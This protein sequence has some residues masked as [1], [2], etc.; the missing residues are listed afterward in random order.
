MYFDMQI[1]ILHNNTDRFSRL[2]L[3]TQLTIL[4]PR[5]FSK[6]LKIKT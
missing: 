2:H 1:D 6:C 5:M 3:Y 4:D